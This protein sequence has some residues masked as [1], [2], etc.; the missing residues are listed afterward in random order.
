MTGELDS[1][2]REEAKTKIR[3]LGGEVPNSVSKQTDYLI[4]GKNPGSKYAK[5]K[6]LGLKIISEKEFLEI[7]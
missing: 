4:T 6:K 1:Y 3:Q 2:T 5:A 7:L